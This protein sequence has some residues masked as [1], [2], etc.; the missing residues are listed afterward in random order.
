MQDYLP[1]S[2]INTVVFCPRRYYIEVVL[3]ETQSNVHL[4]EG[5][6]LHDRAK[7]EGAGNWVWSDELG[8]VGVVDQLVREG[9]RLIP[10]E[11]KKGWLG[12]H[13]SDM[14]QLCAQ[15]MCL[16]EMHGTSVPY[17]FIYYHGTRR[18][19]RVDFTPELREKVRAAVRRM[20]EL[21]GSLHYP[22]VIDNKSKCRGCSVRDT[23]QP[24]LRRP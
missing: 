17:G 15:A 22:P 12:E 21:E 7:R 11:F 2:K 13:E 24:S 19:K 16:E 1:I 9:E 18:K 4:A 6:N 3:S 23:C 20:R 14:V 8:I 5:H 10:T